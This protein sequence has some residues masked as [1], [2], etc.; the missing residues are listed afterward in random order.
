MTGVGQIKQ[1]FEERRARRSPLILACQRVSQAY[2]NDLVLPLPE[3]AD[4]ELPAVANLIS[5]GIDQH[6]MRI[7][8]V[9]P[10]VQ[11]PPTK[12]GVQVSE[13][14][15]ALRRRA[16][17]G[18]WDTNSYELLVRKRA[19]WLI[20]YSNAPAWV[21]PDAGKRGPIFEPRNP[22]NVFACD[23][24]DM[25]PDDVIFAFAKTVG[26]L[27][28]TY[29]QIALTEVAVA[30]DKGRS[31]PL[32]DGDTVDVLQWLD[33]VETVTAIVG[34]G[35]APS[36]VEAEY[37]IQDGQIIN[38]GGSAAGDAQ[39]GVVVD[40]A[41]NRAGVPQVVTPSRIC[42][43][44]PRGQFDD[45]I[46]L[47]EMQAKLTA[48]EVNAIANGIWP[49]LYLV[50]NGPNVNPK[51]ITPADGRAGRIGEISNGTIVPIQPQP[52]LQTPTTIDRLERG[53][54]LSASI[55]AD[56]SGESASN[57]RTARR[58]SAIL[59]EAV[60]YTIQEHQQLL[61][62]SMQHELEIAAAIDLNYFR[63]AKK[64]FY[65]NWPGGKGRLDYTP[66]DIWSEDRTVHV[67]YAK[68]GAD[69]QMLTTTTGELMGMGLMSKETG[70]RRHPDIE[71]PEFETDQIVYEGLQAALLSGIQQQAAAGQL[72]PAD[73]ARIAQRVR[74]DKADLFTSVINQQAEAQARQAAAA[75]PD[76]PEAQPGL[77]QPG[78]GAEASIAP[79]PAS[80]VNL[81]DL[82][83]TLASTNSAGNAA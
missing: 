25:Y 3:V 58:G 29:P 50:P 71:D 54:R 18:F 73:V 68:A 4:T 66:S 5:A 80:A 56:F 26:W 53:I 64:S 74:A 33:D 69:E 67:T 44:A 16:C 79:P 8:S 10:D 40:R 62:R 28:Y 30:L 63:S 45:A 42:L 65:V 55:P 38:L 61:A 70:M 1:A 6:A 13:N 32:N 35:Y 11:C 34:N 31:R 48:M 21:R 36:V 51:I 75:P 77:A 2:N 78:A 47:W 83:R 39:W 81:K 52:G 9:L 60:D 49:D 82:L 19:R 43:D 72:P 12:P 7:A 17:L 23:D 15:A 37:G 14:R 24:D 46:G 20:A 57:V 76:A 22:L 27:R 59:S 41:V